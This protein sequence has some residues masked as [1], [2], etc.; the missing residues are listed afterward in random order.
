MIHCINL[1]ISYEFPDVYSSFT[2]Y[3]MRLFFE[4]N[5]TFKTIGQCLI[6]IFV[7]NV[8]F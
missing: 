4:L 7:D 1:G 8:F 3:E 6:L 2:V 5:K